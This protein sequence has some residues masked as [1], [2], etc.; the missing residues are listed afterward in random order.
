M[1]QSRAVCVYLNVSDMQSSINFYKQLLQVDVEAQ[2]ED[3]WAQFK[4]SEDFRLGLLNPGF[5][6]AFIAKGIDLDQHYNAA[7]IRNVPESI[8]AGNSIVLNLR[9]DN[10]AEEFER[11]Q[12]FCP[13]GISEIMYV[14]FMTPYNCFM[15]QDPDGNL[16]EVADT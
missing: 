2:F 14:N 12:I 9:A 11:I 5:D 1:S 6:K 7:S 3:R 10:L 8:E 4:I 16:I 15:L 13:T